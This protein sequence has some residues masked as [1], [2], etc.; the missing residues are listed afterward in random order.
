[1]D[2]TRIILLLIVSQIIPIVLIKLIGTTKFNR[3]GQHAE[4]RKFKEAIR[5]CL[6]KYFDF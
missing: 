2:S 1:M 4:S 6:G 5:I 3:Y